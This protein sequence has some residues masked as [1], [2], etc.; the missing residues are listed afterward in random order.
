MILEDYI[1]A[2]CLYYI[3]LSEPDDES[4]CCTVKTRYLV[5]VILKYYSDYLFY[6]DPVSFYLFI[7]ILWR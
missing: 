6:Y 4:K 2:Y 5:Q 1:Q 7:F 3:Y